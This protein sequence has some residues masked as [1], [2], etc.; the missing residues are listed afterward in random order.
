MTTLSD[1]ALAHLIKLGVGLTKS[2]L[3]VLF[4]EADIDRYGHD[5]TNKTEMLR[6]RLRGARDA[7]QDSDPIARR[8][9]LT[10]VQLLIER[11]VPDPYKAPPAF[12]ALCESLLADGIKV[13]WNLPAELDQRTFTWVLDERRRPRATYQLLPTDPT[14]VPLGTEIT[15][16][17]HELGARQYGI[18]LNHYRQ[19]VDGLLHGKYESANGALRSALEELVVCLATDHAGYVRQPRANQGGAA[20]EHLTS[21]VHLSDDDGGKLLSGLWKMTHTNGP[22][23]GQSSPDE[24][25][26]RMQMITAIA[27]FLLRRFR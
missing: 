6:S 4:M 7:A 13:V 18:A 27:R 9:V 21:Q 10:F 2:D 3:G 20:I 25:R 22:H 5:E 23:P 17:E 8:G 11:C 14:P 12:V 1:P 24:A 26:M 15:A 19:A 16:L